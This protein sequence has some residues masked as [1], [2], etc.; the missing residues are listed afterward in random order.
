MG[1]I[2]FIEYIYIDGF[3]SIIVDINSWKSTF[4]FYC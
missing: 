1:L 3:K 4:K 2:L